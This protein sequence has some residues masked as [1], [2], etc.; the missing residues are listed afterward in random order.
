MTSSGSPVARRRL[1]AV[2]AETDGFRL[3]EIDL[4]IRGE[5]EATGTRQHGLP[6]FR[7]ARLPRD[8]ELLEAARE[9]L[10]RLVA[11]HNGLDWPGFGPMSELA[12]DRFDR[13]GAIR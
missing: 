9:D 10:D 7:V 11:E 3:A 12:R 1:A 5:G 8:A 2:A 13:T 6:R 4:E